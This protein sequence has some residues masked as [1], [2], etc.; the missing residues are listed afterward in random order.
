MKPS[1][2]PIRGFRDLYPQE[3]AVQNYIFG[4]LKTVADLYVFENYDGP[5]LEPIELYLNKTSK[6][7]IEQQTFQIKDRKGET[8]VMRPEMTPSLARMVANKANE[9]VFPL[10]LFNLGLRY[11]Y[12][13]PQKGRIREFYQVDY[14]ILGSDSLL[15]DAE[16][17]AVAANIFTSLGATEKDF[18]LVINSRTFMSKKMSQLN[19]SE[20]DQKK[21]LSVI[22][23]KDKVSEIKFT[24]MLKEVGLSEDQMIKL[25]DVLTKTTV[26]DDEYFRELFTL[27]RNYEIEKYCKLSPEIVRGLDYY[28]G[29]VFEVKEIGEMK[30]S[31]LG[32]GRY[33]NLVSSYNESA[34]I[35]GVGFALSDVVV[36]EFLQDKNLLPNLQPKPTKYLVTVFSSETIEQSINVTKELRKNNIPAELY[37]DADKKLDKQ[38]KYADRNNIPYAIIIGPEEIKKNALKVKDMK[39]GKQKELTIDNLKTQI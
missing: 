19:I 6:E 38:L 30:R 36:W 12:E 27:L 5:L 9:L 22:D 7:L 10:R 4:K 37:P 29:I 21:V 17:L 25:N 35:Q 13:T 18:Q 39:T 8:L 16:I 1:L 20:E 3:K 33:D 15:A 31:L 2:Q 14:D 24:T 26:E 34:K 23:K 28:T 32:G 11:R